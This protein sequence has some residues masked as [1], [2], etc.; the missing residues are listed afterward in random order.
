MYSKTELQNKLSKLNLKVIK[1]EKN[2]AI[3]KD[4][5]GLCKV[6]VYSLLNGSMPS[7]STA[8]NKTKYFKNKLAEVQP[9]LK[10]SGKYKGSFVKIEVETE[11]GVC[12]CFPNRLLDGAKPSIT[13]ATNKNKYFISQSK[14][15]HGDKYDYSL[16]EYKNANTKVK[17][18]CSEHGAFEQLASNHLRGQT[19]KKCS[20]KNQ[21]GMW[22]KNP[23]NKNKPSKLYILKIKGNDEEFM[24][25]GVSVNL[26]K[27]IRSI[28]N[29]SNKMYKV[30]I[31]KV[32]SG[33][34]E[35]CSKLERRFKNKVKLTKVKYLPKIT[36]CG[37][38]ECFKNF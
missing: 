33:T 12:K 7:V 16:V 5:Y 18:I 30:E 29:E 2:L 25:Y 35:Y 4:K 3:V 32:V 10:V 11:F 23:K 9:N 6:Q 14:A 17:I 13:S 37:K 38:N 22:H 27:R 24:K 31:L 15:V 26:G 21:V 20:S 34:V 8:L 19:C 36:F 1:I 28:V